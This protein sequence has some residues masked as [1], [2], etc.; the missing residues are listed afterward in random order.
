M[1]LRE[2]FMKEAVEYC[3]AMDLNLPEKFKLLDLFSNFWE[4]KCNIY[5]SEKN[6]MDSSKPE[7]KNRKRII[8]REPHDDILNILILRLR[9][10]GNRLLGAINVSDFHLAIRFLQSGRAE[11]FGIIREMIDGKLHFIHQCFAEY[12]TAKWFTGNFSNSENFISNHL[13][14]LM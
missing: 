2:A 6:I 12:S 9:G 13:F 14:K 4:K 5:F 1:M 8:F 7:V 3:S 10:G 11:Q